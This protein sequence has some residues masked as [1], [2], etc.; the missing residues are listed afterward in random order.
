MATLTIRNLPDEVRDALRVQAA[1]RGRSMEAEVRE[2][3]KAAVVV[4]PDAAK[5]AEAIRRLQEIGAEIKK[6]KPEGWSGVDEFLA[7]KHLEGAWEFG[8]V[9][10]A[11]REAWLGQI[12]RYEVTPAELEAFVASR[13]EGA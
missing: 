7:E 9:T 13:M 10:N 11:E 3:L 12:E 5:R 4:K 2:V 1:V 8:R 6:A